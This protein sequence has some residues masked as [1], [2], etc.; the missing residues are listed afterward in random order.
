[1]PEFVGRSFAPV[2]NSLPVPSSFPVPCAVGKRKRS[3]DL[4]VGLLLS[5]VVVFV[6]VTVVVKVL[7][8]TFPEVSVVLASVVEVSVCV[9]T[10]VVILRVE[11]P[12][13][14]AAV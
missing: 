11:F 1:M 4:C 12:L 14:A 9:M 5:F 7:V 10:S 6:L 8:K 2:G 3:C 13:D